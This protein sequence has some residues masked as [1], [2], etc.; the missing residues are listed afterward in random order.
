MQDLAQILNGE[1]L[2]AFDFTTFVSVASE[3]SPEQQTFNL[4]CYQHSIEGAET[5]P[6]T[7]RALH[8]PA[9]HVVELVVRHLGC[10]Q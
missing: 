8:L 4:R 9:P 2:A 6:K 5:N 7:Y 1:Q 10:S 3:P